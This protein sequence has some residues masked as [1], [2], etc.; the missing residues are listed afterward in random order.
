[1]FETN[2][3]LTIKTQFNQ[4]S[5]NEDAYRLNTLL[6]GKSQLFEKWKQEQHNRNLGLRFS[7]VVNFY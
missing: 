7:A 5:V 3:Q 4:S 2:D 1:M 6:S